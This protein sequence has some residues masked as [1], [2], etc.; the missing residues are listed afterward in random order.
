[1]IDD[2]WFSGDIYGV[3]LR[4]RFFISFWNVLQDLVPI[5]EKGMDDGQEDLACIWC[6]GLS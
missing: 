1:M 3:C 6:F 4:G 5:L 2:L